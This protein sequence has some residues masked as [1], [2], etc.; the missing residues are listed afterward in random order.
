[1]RQTE[2]TDSPQ[3]LELGRVDQSDKQSPLFGVGF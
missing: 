2:L 3:P 1:M